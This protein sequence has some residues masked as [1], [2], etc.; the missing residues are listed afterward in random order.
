MHLWM[1]TVNG[2]DRQEVSSTKHQNEQ[3]KKSCLSDR[4]SVT[5]L[6]LSYTRGQGYTTEFAK[7]PYCSCEQM[8][9]VLAG[10][11]PETQHFKL[12]HCPVL[13]RFDGGEDY[14][15]HPDLVR[16]RVARAERAIRRAN[17][18]QRKG[19]VEKEI[20]LDPYYGCTTV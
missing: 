9:R 14:V 16:E 5:Q 13:M 19:F 4:D 20:T 1:T 12:W 7:L 2:Q 3:R 15:L 6:Y 18:R 11:S 17:P 10:I 8:N